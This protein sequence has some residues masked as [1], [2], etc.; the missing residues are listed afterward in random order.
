MVSPFGLNTRN[1]QSIGN[2]SH[3]SLKSVTLVD[4]R[5]TESKS[6]TAIL[7][8]EWLQD[9]IDLLRRRGYCVVGPTVRDSAIVYDEVSGLDDLPAGWTDHQDGGLY[10]LTRRND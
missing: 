10:R 8:K 1:L 3:R 2:N 5:M 9:L 7:A 4:L 6:Y